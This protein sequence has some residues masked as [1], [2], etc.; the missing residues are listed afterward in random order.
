[1]GVERVPAARAIQV[2][3][4]PLLGGQRGLIDLLAVDYTGRLAGDPLGV[5]T[6]G[7]G[8]VVDGAAAEPEQSSGRRPPAGRPGSE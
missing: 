4:E 7:E 1:M 5:M 8:V 3:L 6:Q 2:V